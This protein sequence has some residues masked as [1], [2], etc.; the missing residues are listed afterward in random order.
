MIKRNKIQIFFIFVSVFYMLLGEG[1]TFH[2]LIHGT[3]RLKGLSTFFGYD[4]G[5]Y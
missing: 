4:N 3:L 1:E 5:L 2:Y